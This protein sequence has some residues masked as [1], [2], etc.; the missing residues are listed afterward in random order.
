[1]QAWLP[2]LLCVLLIG[3]SGVYLTRYGDAIAD[4]TGLGGGWI[5]L[6]LLAT[7]TSLPELAAGVSAVTMAHVPDVAVGDVLGSCVFN[8]LILALVDFLKRGQ[9]LYAS[10]GPEH[11]LSAD[12]SILTLGVAG[13][14][15]ALSH[16]GMPLMVGPIALPTLALVFL[17]LAAMATLHHYQKT[18]VINFTSEEPDAFPLLSLQQVA[19][20]YA[21]AASVVVVSGVWLPYATEDIALQTGWHE[22]FAGTLFAAFA[23]SLPEL[24]VTIAALRLGAVDMAVGNLL[25][26]NLFNMVVLAT[27]D[28]LYQ[29]GPLLANVTPVHLVTTLFALTMTG[30]AL[31][32]LY[33]RSGRRWWS[34]ADWPSLLLVALYLA[35][36]SLV[37]LATSAT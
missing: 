3:I 13:T 9:P 25:G 20:R 18:H 29:P 8:L 34:R 1:M 24:V 10:V 12:F 31:V 11:V 27:D 36:G 5:G 6:I 32:A 2:F 19:W 30:T 14:G 35:N 28:L 17:Y 16:I 26:S 7:V 15:L 22:G 4:K 37:Y 23:T 33:Y 21:A